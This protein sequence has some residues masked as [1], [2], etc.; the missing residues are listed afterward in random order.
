MVKDM[1]LRRF[2]HPHI[3]STYIVVILKKEMMSTF[4][5]FHPISLCNLIYKIISKT[6]STKIKLILS[7]YISPA[8]YGFLQNRQIHDV[9]TIA[10][11]CLHS[12]HVKKMNATVMKVNLK[13]A[14]DYLDWGYLR[15]VLHKI[16]IFSNAAEWIIWHAS[17]MLGMLLL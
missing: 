10:Q 17:L 13:K 12:I 14:Y 3:N 8:Q 4:S 15:M 6:I 11:E 16:G 9:V 1:R 7:K 5:K 2:I